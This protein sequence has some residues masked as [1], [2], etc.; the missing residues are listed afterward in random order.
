MK[1]ALKNS[2]TRREQTRSEG[3]K[4][5]PVVIQ[6]DEMSQLNDVIDQTITVIGDLLHQSDKSP[7]Q[8]T[9]N[10]AYK[11]STSLASLTR[12]KTDIKRLNLEVE[13]LHRRAIQTIQAYMR[14]ELAGRPHL[15]NEMLEVADVAADKAF[16]A[17]K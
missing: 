15:V 2:P 17:D 8:E 12:A 9:I 16:A 14:A 5:T 11:L 1:S 4:A 13:G 10:G 6:P 7:T 3:A